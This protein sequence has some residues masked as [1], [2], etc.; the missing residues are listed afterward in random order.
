[1]RFFCCDIDLRQLL[2]R[3]LLDIPIVDAAVAKTAN[4]TDVVRVMFFCH[5]FRTHSSYTQRHIS[6]LND[7]NARL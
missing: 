3:C 4:S 6:V 5:T 2:T 1:M 7:L